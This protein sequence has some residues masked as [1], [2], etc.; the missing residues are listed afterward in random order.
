MS[1]KGQKHLGTTGPV[2]GGKYRGQIL[3]QSVFVPASSSFCIVLAPAPAK[4]DQIWGQIF[5]PTIRWVSL[6]EVE[7]KEEKREEK[8]VVKEEE[9]KVGEKEE[10]RDNVQLR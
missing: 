10:D 4:L 3:V 7:K 5:F 9:V 2:R 8:E 1:H 6:L